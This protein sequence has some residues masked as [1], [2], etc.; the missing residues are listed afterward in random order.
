MQLLVV[1]GKEAVGRI[2]RALFPDAQVVDQGVEAV[3]SH[4][5]LDDPGCL[6]RF[7]EVGFQPTHLHSSEGQQVFRA[8]AGNPDQRVPGLPQALDQGSAQSFAST[9]HQGFHRLSP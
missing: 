6:G 1:I 8:A 7:A 5:L 2:K 3:G 4:R 9:D